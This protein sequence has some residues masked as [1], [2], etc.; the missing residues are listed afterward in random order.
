MADQRTFVRSALRHLRSAFSSLP[1][2]S[3]PNRLIRSVHDSLVTV[4]MS[5]ARQLGSAQVASEALDGMGRAHQQTYR[6]WL[7]RRHRWQ[8]LVEPLGLVRRLSP[9]DRSDP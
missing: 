8:G 5:L 9:L 4:M 2:R 7:A 6:T 1:D 3:Q